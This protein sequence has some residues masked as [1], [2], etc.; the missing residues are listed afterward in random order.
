[1]SLSPQELADFQRVATA[2]A[3]DF[4]ADGHTVFVALD[5]HPSFKDD[6][7]ARGALQRAMARTSLSKASS[8]VG[9]DFRP[10]NGSGREFRI[11]DDTL[12]RRY[13]LRSAKRSTAGELVI[14]HNT[15]S[16]LCSPEEP[17][18]LF[19]ARKMKQHVFAYI[20]DAD[21]QI[22]DVVI[23]PIIDYT[24]G[25]PGLLV[26]GPETSLLTRGAGAVAGGFIPTDEELDL[27]LDDESDE[28]LGE[29]GTTAS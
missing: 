13:R 6:G 10:V 3:Q 27:G 9:L 29:Q 22:E 21:G 4:E 23:A 16:A 12:D 15:D 1:M 19:P 17:D 2:L 5:A 18:G 25:S 24:Q 26:L 20:L 8:Q 14:Q 11:A 28:G 7:A